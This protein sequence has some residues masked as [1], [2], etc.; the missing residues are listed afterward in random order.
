M[1]VAIVARDSRKRR[2]SLDEGRDIQLE[3]GFV[4]A[5]AVAYAVH[6]LRGAQVAA[7]EDAASDL[8]RQVIEASRRERLAGEA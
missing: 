6:V 7:A 1:R 3:P 4:R 5:A 2:A 8:G